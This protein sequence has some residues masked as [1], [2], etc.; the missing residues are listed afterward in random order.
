MDVRP[1]NQALARSRRYEHGKLRRRVQG[2]DPHG[3]RIGKRLEASFQRITGDVEQL[4]IHVQAGPSAFLD[5]AQG[6][7]DQVGARS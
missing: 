3:Q 5:E 4:D 7:R 6:R 2:I 1:I